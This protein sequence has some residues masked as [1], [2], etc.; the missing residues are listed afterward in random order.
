DLLV[1]GA[2]THA[3]SMSRPSTRQ[4]AAK[5]SDGPLVSTGPG[6]R[7][8]LA[9]LATGTAPRA[10]AAFDTR[11][12]KPRLPGSAARAVL[13]RARRR[14]WPVAASPESFWVE[15]TTGPLTDG[16]L[17]RARAWGAGLGTG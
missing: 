13:R 11:V 9:G 5:R 10:V 15:G 16:E 17:D 14:R 2:P 8:W 12:R 6:V 1:V 4:D 3:F 7:E